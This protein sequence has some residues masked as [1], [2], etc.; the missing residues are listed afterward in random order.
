MHSPLQLITKYILLYGVLLRP[1]DCLGMTQLGSRIHLYKVPL[2]EAESLNEIM[3]TSLTY[4]K[5]CIANNR[6]NSH[7]RNRVCRVLW[8]AL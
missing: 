7:I 3:L 2:S 1:L 6:F 8:M 4:V 5:L